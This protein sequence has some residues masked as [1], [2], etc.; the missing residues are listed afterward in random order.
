[1]DDSLSLVRAS[2]RASP[3]CMWNIL[4]VALRWLLI[5]GEAFH[6][7]LSCV[8]LF[9][10]SLV[11]IPCNLP[12]YINW[13]VLVWESKVGLFNT[14]LICLLGNFKRCLTAHKRRLIKKNNAEHDLTKRR[15]TKASLACKFYRAYGTDENLHTKK[16]G[17]RNNLPFNSR[18]RYRSPDVTKLGKQ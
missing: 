15:R 14:D 16:S 7:F 17:E 9:L 4:S 18:Y 11:D 5:H 13:W 2:Q 3:P 6:V 1:M 10:K 8:R 12:T